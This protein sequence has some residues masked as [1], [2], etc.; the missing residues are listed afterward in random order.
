MDRVAVLVDA[1]YLFAQGSI[2]L[3]GTKL[4]RGKLTLVYDAVTAG[5]KT[6]AEA[7]SKLPLLRICW[8]GGTS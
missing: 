6:F 3:C 4:A 8:Y 1:G 7:T 2:E 5:L